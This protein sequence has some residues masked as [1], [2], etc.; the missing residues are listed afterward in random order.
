MSL[1]FHFTRAAVLGTLV[2]I[3]ALGCGGGT[4]E[5]GRDTS[6]DRTNGSSASQSSSAKAS[7]TVAEQPASDGN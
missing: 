7:G 4:H 5:D 2:S 1:P 6:Q 3:F